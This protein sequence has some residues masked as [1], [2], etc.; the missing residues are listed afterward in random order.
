MSRACPGDV[1]ALSIGRF[2]RLCCN[3]IHASAINCDTS[4]FF[5]VVFLCFVPFSR[6]VGGVAGGLYRLCRL[7]VF[8]RYK[9]SRRL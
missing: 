8:L 9:P 4:S 1:L 6:G 3:R 5:F 7:F 2:A